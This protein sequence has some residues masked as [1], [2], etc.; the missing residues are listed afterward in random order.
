M[1]ALNFILVNEVLK[2]QIAE[3]HAFSQVRKK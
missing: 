2:D 1:L 3:M